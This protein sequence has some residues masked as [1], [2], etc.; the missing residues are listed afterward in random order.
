[1][2]HA[3]VAAALTLVTDRQ[4]PTTPQSA[5]RRFR[6][7]VAE[8]TPASV[9]AAMNEELVPLDKPLIRFEGRRAP[10]GGAKALRQAWK[11]GLDSPLSALTGAS[12]AQWG[13][14]D[15]GPPGTVV[16]DITEPQLG[17]RELV[18]SNGVKVS[19]KKTA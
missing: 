3:F 1:P 13:Y 7:H 10:E 16:S 4:I 17:V 6:D 8:I 14:A 15:F 19:L 9:L 12:V 5:L 11:R 18:F 2:N